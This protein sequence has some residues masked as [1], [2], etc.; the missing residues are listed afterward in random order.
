MKGSE[1]AGFGVP[2]FGFRVQSFRFQWV[3]DP[4]GLAASP[5]LCLKKV[6]TLVRPLAPS[7]PASFLK[8]RN[9]E[10]GTQDPEPKPDKVPAPLAAAAGFVILIPQDRT[11]E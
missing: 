6:S 5:E 10:P 9:P 2:G 4:P 3:A 7:A 11:R 8:Y 1:R